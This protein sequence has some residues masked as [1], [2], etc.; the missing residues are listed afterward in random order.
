M[1][2]LLLRASEVAAALGVSRATAYEMMAS[3]TLPTVRIGRAVRVPR[4]GLEDWVR[5]QAS[6]APGDAE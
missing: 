3:G 4:I 5:R 6:V 1:E 2:T